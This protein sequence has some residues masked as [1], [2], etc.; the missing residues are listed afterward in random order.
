ML[1]R[2]G[3]GTAVFRV[4][5]TVSPTATSGLATMFTISPPSG[6]PD[7]NPDNNAAIDADSFVVDPAL[8]FSSDVGC[9]SQP[10]IRLVNPSTGEPI[11]EFMPYEPAFIGGIRVTTGD[12]TGDGIDEIVVAPGRGRVGEV[13]VFTQWGY[14]LFDYRTLPFGANYTSG[15]EL[16]IGDVTGDGIADIVASMSAGASQ[17]SVFRVDPNA[18]DPVI[19]TPVF[20]L[21]PFGATFVGGVAVAVGDVGSFS[22][23]TTRNVTAA[24]GRG[25]LIVASGAGMRAT[26]QVYD[27]SG[28]TPRLVD[29]INPFA[30]STTVGSLTV[31]MGRYDT[32]TIDDIIV[33]S[34]SGGGSRVEVFSGRIDD[35][36]DARLLALAPFA[37]TTRP[38]APVTAAGLDLDRDGIIDGFAFGQGLG[39]NLGMVRQ[40][41]R[42]G[43]LLSQ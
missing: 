3:G 4:T 20:T 19:N 34:G 2:S 14:E 38:N 37:N 6:L 36:A 26:V 28:C 22:G 11:R 9:T 21:Q 39:G 25:E 29:T 43:V 13:R 27:L 18:A 32:D 12:L 35:P 24:D 42:T 16:A 5:A 10:F 23:G 17:V 7:T 15:V 33:S 41:S 40:T 30:G 8:V 1:F 31:S